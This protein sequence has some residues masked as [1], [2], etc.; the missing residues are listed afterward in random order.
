MTYVYGIYKKLTQTDFSIV[1]IIMNGI[2]PLSMGILL[3]YNTA[4][5]PSDTPWY[6]YLFGGLYALSPFVLFL[7]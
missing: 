6:V 4:V 7:S 3:V 2:L 1:Q 5:N